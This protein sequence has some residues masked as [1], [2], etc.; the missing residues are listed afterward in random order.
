LREPERRL[1]EDAG[2]ARLPAHHLRLRVQPEEG[3]ALVFQAK[4]PGPGM[5]LDARDVGKG[6]WAAS[7]AAYF[8]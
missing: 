1:F 8:S 6:S 3:I 4:E 7:G 2:I 5:P